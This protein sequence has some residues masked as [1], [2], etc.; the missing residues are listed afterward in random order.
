[1]DKTHVSFVWIFAI[2]SDETHVSLHPQA[3]EIADLQKFLNFPEQAAGF[4]GLAGLFFN[5]YAI[6]HGGHP[7]YFRASSARWPM[8]LRR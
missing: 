1:M 8:S 2:L 4:M 5:I 6:N 3:G 7:P